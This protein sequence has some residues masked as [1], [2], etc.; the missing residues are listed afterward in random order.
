MSVTR[1]AQVTQNKKIAYFFALLQKEVIKLIFCM[2]ISMK[3][4][5]KHAMIFYENVPQSSQNSK[6][7]MFLQYLKKEVRKKL[8][9]K[10]IF[11]IQIKIKV[12]YK[13]ISTIWGSKFSSRWYYHYLWWW[14]SILKVLKVR[15]LQY[16]YDISK[17]K[18]GII[19][20]VQ[21]SF[22]VLINI[23]VSASWHYRIWW[24]WPDII[25]VPKIRS[26]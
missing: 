6:L 19:F 12:S 13:L 1:H 5:R 10:L 2:Q 3:V 24:K 17:S 21:R 7:S 8:D 25:K 15:S 26:W 14:S 18:L 11:C 20:Y 22:F 4:S 9:M 23:K 16:L